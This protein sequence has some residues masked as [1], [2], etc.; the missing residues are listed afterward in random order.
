[1]AHLAIEREFAEEDALRDIGDDL[2][3]G[4]H[5]ADGDRQIVRRP[6]LAEVGGRQVDDHAV[7]GKLEA[8]VLDRGL[9]AVLR[10]LHGGIGQADDGEVE[11]AASGDVDL[12]LDDFAVQADD[13]EER[14]GASGATISYRR[15]FAAA[16]RARLQIVKSTSFHQYL[17]F[18][19]FSWA[20]PAEPAAGPRR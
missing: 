11:E 15:M 13:C 7:P 5:D 16:V 12:A 18:S 20:G 10:L 3:G 19:A 14:P 4:E 17:V 1:V 9:D 6:L 2:S 8:G